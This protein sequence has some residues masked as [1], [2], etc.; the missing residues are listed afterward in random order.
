MDIKTII[1]KSGI[2]EEI[3]NSI[4]S[5]ETMVVLC[6]NLSKLECRFLQMFMIVE[7]DK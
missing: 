2:K 4:L 1:K 6:P 7:F 5:V 3:G